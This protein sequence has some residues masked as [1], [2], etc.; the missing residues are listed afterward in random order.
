MPVVF[1]Q[2]DTKLSRPDQRIIS[3]NFTTR[4]YVSPPD[5]PSDCKEV[6]TMDVSDKAG[7]V[8][9]ET[10]NDSGS[11]TIELTDKS[12]MGSSTNEGQT[13]MYRF[14]SIIN[15]PDASAIFGHFAHYVPSIEEWVTGKSQFYTLAKECSIE[16]YTD[17][18][19]FNPGLIKV[20]GIAL[21]KFQYTLSYMK[22]FNKKFGYFI[23][24]ITGYGLHTIENGGNYVMYVVCKNV[25]GI[26]D[27]A[28][29]LASGFNKRK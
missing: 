11:S 1:K 10:I 17:E 28:G 3:N 2:C 9:H 26:N 13:P 27:A 18:D 19:G 24:P 12:E 14:G 25:N 16:L 21:S 23:V 15:Y 20:D 22:Y 29:Y 7:T 8:N 5:V 6:F 4:L